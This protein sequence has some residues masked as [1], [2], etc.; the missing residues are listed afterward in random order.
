MG[1]APAGVLELA[2]ELLPVKAVRLDA[3]RQVQ[4]FR[5]VCP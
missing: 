1:R 5:E 4:G 3:L 2:V